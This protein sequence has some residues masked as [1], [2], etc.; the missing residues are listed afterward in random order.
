MFMHFYQQYL[1]LLTMAPR[2]RTIISVTVTSVFSRDPPTFNLSPQEER[3]NP[4]GFRLEID[5]T[6][7]L[8]LE[9][10]E[11]SIPCWIYVKIDRTPTVFFFIKTYLFTLDRTLNLERWETYEGVSRS[12]IELWPGYYRDAKFIRFS[13]WFWRKN[14]QSLTLVLEREHREHTR[15]KNMT[16]HYTLRVF[17]CSWK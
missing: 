10:T 17:C 1:V 4:C 8:V 9:G 12:R 11:T 13:P 7:A 16:R 2:N 14:K 15:L 6:S 3:K 5:R